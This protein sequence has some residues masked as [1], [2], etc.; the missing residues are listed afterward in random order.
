[1]ETR[2]Y[3]C[4]RPKQSTPICEHCGH[5]DRRNNAP[6]QIPVGTVLRGQ[7]VVGKA[8]GQGG[9]G[10]TYLGWDQYL[11]V[12]IAI[13]EYFPGSLVTRESTVSTK[14]HCYSNTQEQ[15]HSS[16][17]RFLREAQALAQFDEVPSI[18]RVR[19]FFEENDTGYIIMEYVRGTDLRTYAR[20]RGGRLSLEETLSI[21]RPIMEALAIVHDAGLVHRDISPDN[22]MLLGQ[23]RAKLLDFG[24]V[25]DVGETDVDKEITKST[26]AILKYG[27]APIEQ[28]QRRGAL[29]PWTDVYALCATIY[30]C[31][32]GT[33]PP[34]VHERLLE[35]TPLQWHQIPGLTPERIQV[36]ERGMALL[37]RDRIRSVRELIDALYNQNYHSGSVFSAAFGA[38]PVQ[39][40]YP[41]SPPSYSYPHTAPLNQQPEHYQFT[42]PV[43]PQPV[44]YYSMNHTVARPA[45]DAWKK[46]LLM[47]DDAVIRC[48]SEPEN[49]AFLG[50]R[51]RRSEITEIT[52][53]DSIANA[54]KRAWDVSQ[55]QDDSVLAWADIEK[56]RVHLYIGAEGGINAKDACRGL[57]KGCANL[58]NIHFNNCF[59]TD[60]AQSLQAMFQH[61]EKLE[62]LDLSQLET[63]SA[64]DM[65]FLFSYCKSL[66]EL[67]L[68]HL[69]TFSATDMSFLFSYCKSLKELD[70][71]NLDTQKVTNM[72]YMFFG[73][74]SLAEPDVSHLEVLRVQSMASMFAGC[75]QIKDLTIRGWETPSLVDTDNFMDR[76][77]RINGKP[78]HKYFA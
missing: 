6:H 49:I 52:F 53:L 54:P 51:F 38:A 1:M 31:L 66:K 47:R 43:N 30:Y 45:P 75:T 34:E 58:R 37:P 3:G 56:Q 22:I 23:N 44:G 62:Q 18:V 39:T 28:Y 59:H 20:S 57:F 10:I 72:K 19:N 11:N 73:C 61:C 50:T 35:G 12:P 70:L 26:E 29:G 64:E 17:L 21:L 8:L 27:F 71:R 60:G 14:I 41:L 78:W 68:S 15:F 77:M 2:C 33:V 32:T 5:D 55:N 7:Y 13:K 46:N 65:S 16:K 74:S 67:D 40:G 42:A 63:S 9:F 76:G 4:M 69:D 36:L 25:R 48:F 24:A